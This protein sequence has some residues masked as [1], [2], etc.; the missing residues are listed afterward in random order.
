M[1]RTPLMAETR[2]AVAA[3]DAE[4]VEFGMT[5]GTLLKRAGMQVSVLAAWG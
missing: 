4:S 3:V 5:R 2:R 1:A